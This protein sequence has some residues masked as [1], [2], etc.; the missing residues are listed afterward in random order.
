MTEEAPG[1]SSPAKKAEKPKRARTNKP[2]PSMSFEDAL[3]VAQGIHKFASGQKVRRITLFDHFDKSPDSGP[4][5]LLVTSSAKYGLT[6][7]SYKADQLELTPEGRVASDPDASPVEQMKARFKLAIEQVEPFQ[8]LYERF[9]GNKMPAK[10][11]MRDTLQESGVDDDVLDEA[12]DTFITNAKFVG[13]LRTLSGAER[14]LSIDHAVEEHI[15]EHP[16]EPHP[17]VTVPG[18]SPEVVIAPTDQASWEKTCFFIAPI[19]EDDSEERQHS[20]L[21][22]EAIVVPALEKFGLRVVRADAIGKSGMIGAQ[23]IEHLL[24]SKVVIADLSFLN[25]N[26][27]YELALR[28]AARL[29]TVHIAR[30]SDRIPFDI[31]QTRVIKI[32]DSSIYTLVPKLETYRSEIA[33]QVRKALDDDTPADNPVSL[34]ARGLTVNNPYTDQKAHHNG[35]NGLIPTP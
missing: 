13:L 27:F 8:L 28:H 22:L 2:F 19:G 20:D 18:Q 29:P 3:E 7:G 9:K 25:P 35:H 1:T 17:V 24:R 31:Q 32:D 4:S 33:T 5:R 15:R 14:L 11:V 6:T 21:F 26:V 10:T 12:V 30:N 16:F 23:V 34:F